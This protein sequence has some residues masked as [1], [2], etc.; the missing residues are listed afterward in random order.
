MIF[1]LLPVKIRTQAK[2]RLA[3]HLT[4]SEREALAR[5]MYE[6]VLEKLLA[7]SGID[8]IVVVTADASAARHARRSGVR[9]FREQDQQSHSHSA[10]RAARRAM[11]LGARTVVLLPIDVPLVTSGEIESLA[12]AA[13]PGVVIVPS[14]DGTGTNALVRTPP[15]VIESRFGKDSFRAHLEQARAKGVAADVMR[16]PGIVFDIDTPEDVAELLVRAPDSRIAG[17]L[18]S[19]RTQWASQS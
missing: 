10:D 7:A 1:A 19:Q 8:R 16:P 6:E 15:D 18:R 2:Q 9:V 5:V 11:E 14:A 3:G 13:R 17:L 4:P 12:R